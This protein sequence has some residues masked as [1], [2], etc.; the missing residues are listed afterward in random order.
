M[1]VAVDAGTLAVIIGIATVAFSLE[2]VVGFGGS[3]LT[4]TCL[5]LLLPASHAVALVPF[6]A[7]IA[8]IV[9]LATGFRTVRYRVIVPAL[10]WSAP[11]LIG[12]SFLLDHLP[13]AVVRVTLAALSIA[14]AVSILVR[15]G[16]V[17]LPFP[18]PLTYAVAGVAAGISS[19]AILYVPAV[20]S[21]IDEKSSA[22]SSMALLWIMLA[23]A[24]GPIF[25][26]RGMLPA[27][28]GAIVVL[29]VPFLIAGISGGFALHRRIRGEW[30]RA[31][32]AVLLA[33]S[34]VLV[35]VPLARNG[36]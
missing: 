35:L 10:C 14:Y 11:G 32:A 18:D 6:I 8:S 23:V 21:N 1:N 16:E 29:S 13:G 24:R 12:G 5:S 26:A 17:R 33:I 27:G 34:G 9:V 3:I 4:V 20:L 7:L 19:I 2:S 28:T 36:V 25:L 22:R 30:Y 31:A 15:S